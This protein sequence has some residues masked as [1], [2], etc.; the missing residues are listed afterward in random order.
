[1]TTRFNAGLAAAV[2]Y[3]SVRGV[4]YTA[5]F[6]SMITVVIINM[7]TTT[8]APAK[9]IGVLTLVMLWLIATQMLCDTWSGNKMM[10]HLERDLRRQAYKDLQK[11]SF[12]E[13]MPAPT[14]VRMYAQF[15]LSV[16]EF[17]GHYMTT[18][19]E[20]AGPDGEPKITWRSW[21]GTLDTAR[22]AAELIA[23][24]LVFARAGGEL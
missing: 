9:I 5:W 15:C 6:M 13:S 20:C 14:C 17:D 24:K 4:L 23:E 8:S 12:D 19:M 11:W 7:F 1:M 18:I 10:A 21:Y 3:M 16:A 2:K 22:D